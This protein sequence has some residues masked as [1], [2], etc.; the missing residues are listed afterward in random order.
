MFG[1]KFP[2]DKKNKTICAPNFSNE[3]FPQIAEAEACPQT[4]VRFSP[5]RQPVRGGLRNQP[6]GGP[7][8][9]DP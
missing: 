3:R 4:L 1:H 6:I 2:I 8:K 5:P 9:Q 7:L